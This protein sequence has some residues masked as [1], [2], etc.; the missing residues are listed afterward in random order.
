MGNVSCALQV[1]V[2]QENGGAL[3]PMLAHPG[4]LQQLSLACDLS[5]GLAQLLSGLTGIERLAI[6]G[7]AI[8]APGG[9]LRC[10]S[11][12]THLTGVQCS[13]NSV[14]NVLVQA[15]RI[16]TA[17]A[18]S[19]KLQN[20]AESVVYAVSDWVCACHAALEIPQLIGGDDEDLTVRALSNPHHLR[21]MERSWAGHIIQSIA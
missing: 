18:V 9:E 20:H 17:K 2:L 4:K 1:K 21:C 19:T 16:C 15:Y 12:L 6:P 14:S 13:C 3:A 7:M 11:A 8:A 5:T 10:L